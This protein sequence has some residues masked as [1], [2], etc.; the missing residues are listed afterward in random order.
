ITDST[1]HIY[2]SNI[3][4]K[5]GNWTLSKT[6]N[7]IILNNGIYPS[8]YIDLIEV[9]KDSLVIGNLRRFG[10]KGDNFGMDVEIYYKIK[11]IN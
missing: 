8:D 7:E 1:Y 4:V 3:L 6:G 5:S 11:L 2:E 9:N 10:P